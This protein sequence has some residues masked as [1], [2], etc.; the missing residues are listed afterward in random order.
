[1]ADRETQTG[2]FVPNKAQPCK[3]N[4]QGDIDPHPYTEVREHRSPSV[5]LLGAHF[6][7]L[8]SEYSYRILVAL[9]ADILFRNILLGKSRFLRKKYPPL[10][11][12]RSEGKKDPPPLIPKRTWVLCSQQQELLCFPSIHRDS[13]TRRVTP[14]RTGSNQA[15]IQ[16]SFAN[17]LRRVTP[18]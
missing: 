6:V 10:P 17:Y 8:L 14:T 9:L 11:E 3:S 13:S 4:F 15:R 16:T 7:C 5:S 12:G 1:V 2:P 18:A